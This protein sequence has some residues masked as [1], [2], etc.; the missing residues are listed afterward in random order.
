MPGAARIALDGHTSDD[1][2]RCHA[3]LSVYFL[4]QRLQRPQHLRSQPISSRRIY[5]HC[6]TFHVECPLLSGPA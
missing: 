4:E 2:Y 5:R 1:G 6:I 3:A